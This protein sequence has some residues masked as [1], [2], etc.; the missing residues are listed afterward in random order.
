MSV[1]VSV[2][3]ATYNRPQSL[4]A[5][6]ESIAKQRGGWQLQ[7]C[8]VNDGGT[9]I[10]HAVAAF[11]RRHPG[12]DVRWQDNPDRV[13]QVEARNRAL[14]MATGV[15]IALCDDDDRWLPGHLESLFAAAG[16]LWAGGAPHPLP[17]PGEDL[18]L[19]Y[20]DTELVWLDGDPA[21]GP[22]D[23]QRRRP[24]AWRDAADLL[25]RCNPIA[26]SSVL[27]PR[28]LHDRIGGFD[29]RMSHYWDWDFWLRASAVASL[30]RAARCET[31][32]GISAAGDNLSSDPDRMRPYLE[33]LARKHDLGK[34][35][36]SNFA[37]MTDDPA[38][39]PYQAA[40]EV[41]WGG[42]PSIWSYG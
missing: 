36:P 42:D 15:Y 9:S 32:Y 28:V 30:R 1:A 5:C 13:G 14:E 22:R 31:L 23:V 19:A 39:T 27:Y 38:L 41:V 3:V 24:F 8:V 2:L 16:K 35:E 25:R 18:W 37:R 17:E 20:T 40:T 12:V 6:L 4:A 26:P 7:V 10:R 33:R 11:A 34:L 29:A 21:E